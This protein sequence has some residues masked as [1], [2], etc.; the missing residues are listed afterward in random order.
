M[1]GGGGRGA[2]LLRD[3]RRDNTHKPEREGERK[4]QPAAIRCGDR[5]TQWWF[6]VDL[7]RG[8]INI[9]ARR[10]RQAFRY[11]LAE[12]DSAVIGC[13]RISINEGLRARADVLCAWYVVC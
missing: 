10:R 12:L 2:R 3:R 9:T 4:P 7:H 5:F 13:D 8:P 6:Q 11:L 1:L